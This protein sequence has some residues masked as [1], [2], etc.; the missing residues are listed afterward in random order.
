VRDDEPIVM[1]DY[2]VLFGAIRASIIV[3]LFIVFI[4]YKIFSTIS[5]DESLHYVEI[6]FE[7]AFVLISLF[8]LIVVFPKEAV[9]RLG[10]F[11][12]TNNKICYQEF[13]SDEKQDCIEIFDER[14]V[15]DKY[16]KRVSFCI[17]AETWQRYGRKHYLSSWEL[18]KK[19]PIAIPLTKLLEFICYLFGYLPVLLFK[20]YKLKKANEPLSLL[21]K[22]I[23]IEFTNRNYFLVNIYSQREFDELMIY[24]KSKNIPIQDKTVFLH[25]WQVLNK[26]FMNKEETWCDEY[27]KNIKK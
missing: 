13:K 22:N 9:Q 27:E 8:A 17:M 21:K 25:H 1:K 23:V 20:I 3:F 26:Y 7:I 18:F 4:L 15:C 24:F 2:G 11:K 14:L 5:S 12:F 6:G 16:V 19:S 10:V